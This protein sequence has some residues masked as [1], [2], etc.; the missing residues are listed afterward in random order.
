MFK[1]ALLGTIIS[2]VAQFQ[3][4]PEALPGYLAALKVGNAVEYKNLR[5]FPI[6]LT[7]KFNSKNYTTLDQAMNKGWLKI[8]EMGDGEVNFVEI[9]N[10]G[11]G[12]VFLLTGE[13]IT[14]AKQDRML[15][16]DILLPAASGWVQVPVYCV[17][18]GRWVSVS[19]EFKSGGLV[20]PNAVRQ[21][22][23]MSES[24]S[25]VWDEVARSQAE[26]G[27]AS[28]TGTARANYEDEEVQAKLQD[29]ERQL[30]NLPAL[31]DQTVGVVV[32]T[33]NRIIC[34]DLFANHELL[35]KL[36]PKLLKSYVMDAL[37]SAKTTVTRDDADD[38]LSVLDDIQAVS[39]GTPGLGD[40]YSLEHR[41]GKGCALIHSGSVIHLDWFPIIGAVPFDEGSDIHLDFRRDLRITD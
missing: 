4:I 10:T 40:L 31:S 25:D 13:M 32:A 41:M 11:S 23:K 27:V 22:A 34:V 24:Q 17:E 5:I 28:G 6:T 18:H 12:M 20:V 3:G 35:K 21:R 39:L 29:Y 9:K 7:M 8:R 37:A 1:T 26:L 30:K 36:W 38:F 33:G 14:G 2:L 16:E 15:K 19:P